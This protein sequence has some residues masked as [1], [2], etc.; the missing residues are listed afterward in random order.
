[1]AKRKYKRDKAGKFSSNG[2]TA[3]EKSKLRTRARA[4]VK[5]SAGNRKITVAGGR[6]VSVFIGG[7]KRATN[8]LF[9]K[10]KKKEN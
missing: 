5:D 4:V 8:R 2:L 9:K 10:R 3:G 6:S 1:M 7:T